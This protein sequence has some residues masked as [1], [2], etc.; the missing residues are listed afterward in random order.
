MP[1]TFEIGSPAWY[2]LMLVLGLAVG[3]LIA[4]I[5]KIRSR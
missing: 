4:W 1:M 5:R 2:V 3:F